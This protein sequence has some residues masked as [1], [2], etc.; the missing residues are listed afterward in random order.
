MRQAK[1]A[2]SKPAWQ[3]V[4][5]SVLLLS[6]TAF[7]T[8]SGAATTINI[9]GTI[10]APPPCVINGDKTIQV[11]FG[12]NVVISRIDGSNYLKTIDY[13]LE[14]KSQ[15]KNAMKMM[16]E[17]SGAGFDSGV[18]QTVKTDLGIALKQNGQPLRL[19]QWLNFTYP[20]QPVL[21]AVPVKKAG[22]NL[23]TGM[24][25]AGATLKVDYQ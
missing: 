1:R 8:G 7:S 14:C 22:A 5:V 18:I 21:Q 15:S 23:P 11:D 9:S 19:N 10:M 25:F 12:Q 17:G 13:T 3:P 24:F 16:I 2:V 6:A 20:M 4:L